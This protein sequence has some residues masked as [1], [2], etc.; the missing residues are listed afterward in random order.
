MKLD[1]PIDV[2]APSDKLKQEPWPNSFLIL[3]SNGQKRD[4]SER[5][6]SKREIPGK[7]LS[8]DVPLE[9]DLVER[10]VSGSWAVY[11]VDCHAKG[12]LNIAGKAEW[13]AAEGLKTLEASMK[14]GLEVQVAIGLVAE[15]ELKK[16]MEQE[17]ARLT[18][19]G[20]AIP[21]IIE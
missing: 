19:P 14:G 3:D 20:F 21:K 6:L 13:N 7:A 12:H 16:T 1:I 5:G 15:V 18:I 8:R 11:C 10:Q 4:L 9:R 17:I 2:H